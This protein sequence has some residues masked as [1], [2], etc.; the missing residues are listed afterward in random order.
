[1]TRIGMITPSS[2]TTLE[3]VT[4]RLLAHRSD[5]EIPVT[6][7]RVQAISLG[8]DGA[9]FNQDEFV[10]AAGLLAD[11][12]VDVIAWNGTSGSWLGPEHDRRVC[13]AITEATGVPATTST[14]AILQAC[15]ELGVHRLGLA[16]PYTSDVAD[17]I[18]SSYAAEGLTVVGRAELGLSNNFSF[19]EVPPEEV[20]QLV[21][22][23]CPAEAEA[24]ALVCTDVDAATGAE[25]LEHR[26]GRPIIDSI[27]ATLWWCLRLAGVDTTIPGF[28]TLLGG[29]GAAGSSAG[30]A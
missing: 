25:A 23:A 8:G 12:K 13:Q 4:R 27:A 15:R 17:R 1:M 18:V 10:R 30:A 7:I 16:T 14:L 28:G 29:A 22:R 26:L 9:D 20:A 5:I 11:A 19:A 2:N 6:R 24:V 21:E 3:P